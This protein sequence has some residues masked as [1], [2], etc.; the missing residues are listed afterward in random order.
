MQNSKLVR[1]LQVFDPEELKRLG[2]FLRSPFYN[3]NPAIVKL[4]RLL[5]S[6]YPD[7]EAPK[8][9]E[10]K[11]FKKLFPNRA[12]DHQ[13]MLNL[14]SDFTALLEKYLVVLQ[15]EAE[16]T[17]QKKL[18]LRAYAKRPDCYAVF[19]KKLSGVDKHLDAK[20][21]RNEHYYREKMELNLQFFSHPGTDMA[22]EGMDSLRHALQYFE[23]YKS[24]AGAKLQC[25]RNDW[26]HAVGTR[27]SIDAVQENPAL[28][29]PVYVLYEKLD[30]LQREPADRTTMLQLVR[31]FIDHAQVFDPD[32]KSNVL[33]I[34]LNYSNRLINQGDMDS[35]KTSLELY[36]T[37]LAYDCFL[38]QGKMKET[39]FFNIVTAG[40]RCREFEWTEHFMQTYQVLLD[41]KVR[42]D[43]LALAKGQW[44]LEK[45]EYL[46]ATE[47]LQHSF[48]EPQSIVKAKVLLAR[49]W[50]ELYWEDA[51]YLELLLSQ[52]DAFDKHVWRNKAV[53]PRLLK[54]VQSFIGFT[55][56][57][58][59]RKAE[60]KAM[61]ELRSAIL[62]EPN[63]ILKDWLLSKASQLKT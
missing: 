42:A 41:A 4:Y 54:G 29:N 55:R 49:S 38:V 25:A 24:L 62:Q 16:E 7:F 60:G 48:A 2:K 3:A 21:Y 20:P 32:D 27:R 9:T 35:I 18:L 47:F 8:M 10:E 52:L 31:Y 6:G 50:C 15:L 26:R 40:T 43:A 22:K 51:G 44:H 12:Y 45:Q 46:K 5:R 39:T 19:S 37:G 63:V 53:A 33:K 34:L 13:K 28:A 58:A 56:K 36:K 23:A 59:L 17:L 57:L 30:S 61:T 11:V 1:T 14:M